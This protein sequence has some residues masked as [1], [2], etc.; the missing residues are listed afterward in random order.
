MFKAQI[1]PG[2]TECKKTQISNLRPYGR[3]SSG[4]NLRAL[5][6]TFTMIKFA[7]NL[8]R[9]FHYS[10]DRT[11]QVTASPCHFASWADAITT[12]AHFRENLRDCLTTQVCTQVYIAKRALLV[13]NFGITVLI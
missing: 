1:L 10:I 9:V 13:P 12:R 5:A 3:T 4:H 11:T 6:L 8:T 7:Q 2:Q